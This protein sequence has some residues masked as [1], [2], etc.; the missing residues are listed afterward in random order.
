[1]LTASPGAQRRFIE[2]MALF[3]DSV[4]QQARDR[5]SGAIP[6]LESYIALRRD[7]SGCKP[8]WALLEC[9][10]SRFLCP[11]AP[12]DRD[13]SLD[14]YN[15]HLPDEVMEHQLIASI[16]EAANDLVTWSNV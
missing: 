14:A 12:F 8:C 5:D 2:T 16:E 6:D 9:N 15:L 13:T 1:M 10:P 3:F 11:S 4:E 7:T